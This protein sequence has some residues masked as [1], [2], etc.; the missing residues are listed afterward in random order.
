MNKSL[1]RVYPL[2]LTAPAVLIYGIFFLLPTFASFVMAFTDWHLMKPDIQ[3]NGLENFTYL[4]TDPY[5]KS[6]LRNTLV[7]GVLST[8]LKVICGLLLALAL[9]KN[10]RTNT[11]LRTIFFLPDVLSY[12][13]V[14]IIFHAL[15]RYNGVINEFLGVIGC[16]QLI[17]NWLG[18]T[19]TAFA[20]VILMDVWKTSGFFMMVFIAGLQGIPTEYYEAAAIDGASRLQRFRYI[21]LPLLVAS[22]TVNVTI[23]MIGGFRVFD[24]IY[25]LTKG[26]PA[27]TTN[28]INTIVFQAQGSGMYGRGTAMGLVLTVFILILSMLVT[29]FLGKKEVEM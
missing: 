15:L 28:V 22:M 12:V 18:S 13:V 19:G 27:N 29:R 3:F 11:Y 8:A 21:T 6:A 2:Y 10:L 5:F 7:Y 20:C 4:F 23:A 1:K 25:V 9:S 17:R 24:Q 14:G 16:P 26:G